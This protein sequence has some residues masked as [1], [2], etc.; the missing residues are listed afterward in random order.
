MN[1]YLVEPA[2]AAIAS[3]IN[4]RVAKRAY[5]GVS[6][7]NANFR[8]ERLLALL[9]WTANRASTCFLMVGSDVARWS[10][11]IERGVP[12]AIASQTA[13]RRGRRT[14]S[15]VRRAVSEVRGPGKFVIVE[16]ADVRSEPRFASAMSEIASQYGADV[17]FADLVDQSAADYCSRR[18]AAGHSVAVD[19][20]AALR[21][22]ANFI[23]EELAL[24]CTLVAQG[25]TVEFYP[26]PELPVLNAA[27]SGRLRSCPPE[28][29]KRTNVELVI[30]QKSNGE[31]T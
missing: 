4:R 18:V 9:R 16:D 13:R 11:M 31:S 27:A 6:V 26:G 17:E 14:L 22:S 3:R 10:Y 1:Q 25:A 30:T 19:K 28:L 5:V 12:E 8:G 21:L 7:G 24:F 20:R 29:R 15:D 23:L 2:D